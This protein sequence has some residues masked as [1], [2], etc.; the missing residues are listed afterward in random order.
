VPL[1]S[2]KEM[3]HMREHISGM[4][5]AEVTKRYTMLGGSIRNVLRIPHESAEKMVRVAV[6]NVTS[7]DTVMASTT[8]SSDR[9]GG[10]VMNIVS[11]IVHF[12]V[13]EDATPEMP[14]LTIGGELID[15]APTI[16]PPYAS[17]QAVFASNYV[18]NHVL[19]RFK[20]A[21]MSVLRGGQ[22]DFAVHASALGQHV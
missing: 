19:T 22:G 13:N 8:P 2:L 5:I 3:L 21:F 12:S 10:D 11:V 20:H 15:P 1:V 4:S 17:Y 6:E 16:V 9:T 18:R 14:L 7:L